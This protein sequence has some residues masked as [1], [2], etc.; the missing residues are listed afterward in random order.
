MFNQFTA[1]IARQHLFDTTQEVVVAVSGGV[2]SAVLAHLMHRAGYPF[3]I[4]HCNFNLRPG[5]CDDDER[6][7]RRLGADYGV[8]VHVAH[9]LTQTR[10]ERRHEGIEETARH[11]RYDFFR[12]LCRHHGYAAVLVAHHADDSAETFFLNLLRGTG[13]SGLHG[14]LPRA[15]LPPSSSAAEEP[16]AAPVVRPLLPFTRADIETYA[17]RHTL[18]HVT[19]VTNTSLLYKR[20]QVRHSLM[21]LLRQLQPSADAAIAATIAHL[22]ATEALYRHLLE[23]LRSCYLDTDPDGTHRLHLGRLLAEQPAPLHS[24]LLFEL[25]HPYGFN[26]TQRASLLATQRT[27]AGFESA[28]HRASYHRG[29][30]AIVP[31][32]QVRPAPQAAPPDPELQIALMSV[33]HLPADYRQQAPQTIYLD[34]DTLRQPVSL[35]HW[36]PADRFRPLGLGGRSQLV[37][38]YFTD[39]HFTPDEKARQLLLVDADDTILWIVGRR[40]T[41]PHRITDATRFVVRMSLL[42]PAPTMP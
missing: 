14:I 33:K 18:S 22:E 10:A 1:H 5:D 40:T 31:K 38:D 9:F 42:Q 4:A 28:T 13:L 20:N 25:L 19:D 30:L 7:V 37:S 34:A 2:D 15:P 36:Q 23:P 21:P 32:W 24:Q 17:S 12:R 27:G 3:A 16:S 41:H 35:R 8:P 29:V 11:L 39:H 6:F 26:A